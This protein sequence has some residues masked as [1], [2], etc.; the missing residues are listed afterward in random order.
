FEA[1]VRRHGPMVLGICRRV[2]GD[3]HEADD[4]FQAAFLVLLRRAASVVPRESVGNWLY[5][6]AF[7]TALEA[8]TNRSRRR[9]P[10]R[11]SFA[12]STAWTATP[13]RRSSAAAGGWISTAPRS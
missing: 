3:V 8:R 9:S 12:I 10:P 13:A 7:R 1:L 6:V 5:G 4:A 2:L 11:S